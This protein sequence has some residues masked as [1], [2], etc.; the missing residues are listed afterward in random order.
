MTYIHNLDP[1][2]VSL[3]PLAIRW[4][5]LMYVAGFVIGYIYLKKST[6]AKNKNF[7]EQH[8]ENILF[9]AAL[10][11]IVGG[12]LG[13]FIF[14]RWST[15]IS[16][17]LEFFYVW[18]GGM[19]AHGGI[20]GVVIAF[21]IFAW[22]YKKHFLDITDVVVIPAAIG[23]GFGRIANFINGEL[24]GRMTDQS[25]GV[26]FPAADENLRHPTQLYSSAQQFMTGLILYLVSKSTQK[27]G[28]L[29]FLFALCYGIFRT[30]VE[31][32][33]REPLDGY[34]GMFTAGQFYS[35]PLIFVGI[36][37]LV[38]SL[39]YNEAQKS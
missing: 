3:G 1:I 25:W 27:R 4:Y 31:A 18:N 15:L 29:S 37:G 14:Y 11:V 38:Y 5:G 30:L 9:Y 23:L 35:I 26:V 2:I 16:N 34:I 32:Y 8:I 13:H 21:L 12:R 20:L 17:P 6:F 7:T 10:G 24:W 22:R 19:S 28:V 36:I 33:W 39:L